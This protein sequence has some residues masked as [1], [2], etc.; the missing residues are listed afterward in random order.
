MDKNAYRRMMEQ[1]V[2]SAALI[3]KTKN[4]MK[5]EEVLPTGCIAGLKYQI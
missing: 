4:R 2:P 3:Q 1:A 5:Q